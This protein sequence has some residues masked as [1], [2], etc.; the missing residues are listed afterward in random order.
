MAFLN[1]VII[2]IHRHLSSLPQIWSA[3]PE[4]PPTC[5]DNLTT[6]ALAAWISADCAFP[7]GSPHRCCGCQVHNE[8]SSGRHQEKILSTHS[9][10]YGR[11]YTAGSSTRKAKSCQQIQRIVDYRQPVPK[12]DYL[13]LPVYVCLT[14]G[15]FFFKTRSKS[16]LHPMPAPD[17]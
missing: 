2:W 3:T 10:L 7:F 4:P 9:Y 6:H 14:N 5:T 8:S 1:E 15:L 11:L 12:W 13:P 16:I 17:D